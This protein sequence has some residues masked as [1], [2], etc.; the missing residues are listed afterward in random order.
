MV[1]AWSGGD[2]YSLTTSGG[3]NFRSRT[4]INAPFA[5]ARSLFRPL[6]FYTN[7]KA[8]IDGECA[9]GSCG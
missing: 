9:S 6:R 7:K 5:P 4:P 8:T 3:H 1:V 2:H